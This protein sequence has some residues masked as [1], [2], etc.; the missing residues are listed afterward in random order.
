MTATET[1]V[2]TAPAERQRPEMSKMLAPIARDVLVP[3]AAY[4]AL[5]ALGYSD[6]V[7]LLAGAVVSAIIVVAGV[8]RA[9]S[10]DLFAGIVLGGFAIGLVASLIS[11]DARLIIVRDSFGTAAVGTA[12]LIATLLGKPLT[13]HAVRKALA[14]TARAAQIQR[15]YEGNAMVRR[16]HTRLSVMWAVG[17]IAEAAVRVVL[18]YQLPISTMAWLS[19]VLMAGTVTVLTVVTIRTAKS[20]RSTLE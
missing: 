11:G 15:D 1:T 13:Y 7:A 14:G 8:V 20:M 9:R 12:F 10:F 5:H 4:Y 2:T 16:T 18:A 19:T 6:F 17:L 3:M